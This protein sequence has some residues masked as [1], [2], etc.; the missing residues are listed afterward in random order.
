M[1]FFPVKGTVSV[2]PALLQPP[3]PPAFSHPHHCHQGFV[4][5]SPFDQFHQPVGIALP[6]LFHWC[7]QCLTLGICKE[8]AASSTRTA[9]PRPHSSTP[10]EGGGAVTVLQKRLWG[11][12]CPAS[13]PPSGCTTQSPG[14]GAHLGCGAG[15][16]AGQR[17]AAGSWRQ[18]CASPHAVPPEPPAP[19]GGTMPTGRCVSTAAG[20]MGT[21]GSRRL[22]APPVH[23]PSPHPAAPRRRIAPYSR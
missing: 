6:K 7:R 20:R 3:A 16:S 15:M 2:G 8:N 21:P 22:P 13:A 23:I 19:H 5:P 10:Q 12:R 4:I 9:P 11:S 18:G 1:S 17:S 14:K